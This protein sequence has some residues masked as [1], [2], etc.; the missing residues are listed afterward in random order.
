MKKL[1][2]IIIC[3]IGIFLITG[4]SSESGGRFDSISYQDYRKMIEN[5]ESFVLEVMSSDCTHCKNLKPKL[6]KVIK[7]YGVV[8]KVMNLEALSSEDYKAFTK[9]IGTQST[10]TII[11][12]QEGYETSV[13]TRILG[14][15]SSEKIIQKFQ[16][17]GIIKR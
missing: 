6:Q 1:K 2:G 3:M 7:D 8:V 17:N 9:E 15:V 14:D 16:D 4:C 11:F 10:P 5:K 12:Y 13:A